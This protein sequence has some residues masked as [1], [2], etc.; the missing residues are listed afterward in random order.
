MTDLLDK[1]EFNFSEHTKC[2]SN[3][4]ETIKHVKSKML[5]KFIYQYIVGIVAE[6]NYCLAFLYYDSFEYFRFHHMVHTHTYCIHI[7]IKHLVCSRACFIRSIEEL[8]ADK[9]YSGDSFLHVY[10]NNSFHSN[11]NETYRFQC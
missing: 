11:F 1:T 3:K 5:E 10:T 9:F 7:N 8:S 6:P 2:N 4:R